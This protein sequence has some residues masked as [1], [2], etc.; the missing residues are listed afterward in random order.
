MYLIIQ[1]QMY[2][3][4]LKRT[5]TFV[6][7]T[8]IIHSLQSNLP[9]GSKISFLLYIYLNI[10]EQAFKIRSRLHL[11]LLIAHLYLPYVFLPLSFLVICLQI[12]TNVFS[13]NLTFN[14]YA[15]RFG[16]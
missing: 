5:F 11:S 13:S 1:L 14:N 15:V 6:V 10:L 2:P 7:N 16:P 3:D 12:L 4:K 8:Y 9:A